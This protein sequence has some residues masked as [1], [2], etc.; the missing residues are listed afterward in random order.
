MRRY[1]TGPPHH[2]SY[3]GRPAWSA[4]ERASRETEDHHGRAR[5]EYQR[6]LRDGADALLQ[7]L[8]RTKKKVKKKETAYPLRRGIDSPS[9]ARALARRKLIKNAVP[10]GPLKSCCS[11][12]RMISRVGRSPSS[13]G[14]RV[15]PYYTT[16]VKGS[17]S[18]RILDRQRQ[19]CARIIMST[20]GNLLR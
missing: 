11:T 4:P 14:W 8:K 12:I 19:T 16:R 18:R 17:A 3:R 1:T 10:R 13:D 15:G 5:A 7:P 20:D 6:L 9:Q 2:E